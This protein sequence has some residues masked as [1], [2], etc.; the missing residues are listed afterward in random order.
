MSFVLSARVHGSAS[1][2]NP[3]EDLILSGT[4]GLK[5]TTFRDFFIERLPR[6]NA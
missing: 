4:F 1:W 6:E 5:Q 3:T 2:R